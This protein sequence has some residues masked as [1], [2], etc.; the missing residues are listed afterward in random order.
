MKEFDVIVVGGGGAGIMAASAAAAAGVKVALISKEPVGYGNTRMAVGLTA[1]AGIDGDTGDEFFNDMINSGDGLCLPHLVDVL[2]N[3]SRVALSYA[4]QLGHTFTRNSCNELNGNTVSRAGGHTQA[5]TLQSSGAGV[6]LGQ[7]LRAAIE[8]YKFSCFEDTLVIELIKRGV[9]ICG[10]RA[11][12]LSSGEEFTLSCGA[13]V[14]ATGGAG[15]IFYPQTSNNRGTCGDGYALAFQAGAQLMDMEQIQAIP[16]GIT[17]PDAYRGLICGEPLVAGPFGRI[18]DGRGNEV[19]GPGIH[20]LGRATVVSE[21]ADAILSGHVS[22]HGGL[23]LDLQPNLQTGE[24]LGYRDRIRATGITDTVLPAYGKKAY[25]WEE[26]WEVLP[27]VHFFMGGVHA[28]EHGATNVPGLYVA[29]EVMGGIHGGNRL[30]SVAL[31]EILVYGLSAG[32]AAAV[33]AEGVV[34]D[35]CPESEKRSSSLIGRQGNYRPTSLCRKLQQLMWENA[36]LVRDREGLQLA[37]EELEGIRKAAKDLYISNET[38][39]NLELRDAYELG[40]MLDTAKLILETA[41]L[42]EESR[43]AH[44]RADFPDHGG[45][46][47]QK[48]IYLWR[49][50][51][52][53]VNHAI[54]GWEK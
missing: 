48:N 38:I 40:F 19:L 17:F 45:E 42:R 36:G 30:G 35:T 13:V 6:G 33:F 39:F 14:L 53:E 26:P 37:V 25:D 4:E 11:L 31:T 54:K 41:L 21:M 18:L 10:V 16:F 1:C 52:G 43:G 22:E 23:Y 9:A 27:T 8:K 15:W 2:V 5:R 28:D 49:G 32:Q 34:D 7:S 51:A 50:E 3:Q 47:W 29:G 20:R 12:E 46:K 24:G 44:I